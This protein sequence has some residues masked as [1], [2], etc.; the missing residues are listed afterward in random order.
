MLIVH[1]LHTE[2]GDMIFK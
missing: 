2:M 1:I